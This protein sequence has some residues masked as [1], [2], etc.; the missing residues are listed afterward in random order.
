MGAPGSSTV[1]QTLNYTP[2]DYLETFPFL[3]INSKILTQLGERYHQDR[4]GI[5]RSDE[6]GLT[7]FYNRIHDP[8]E[9]DPR[10]V[11]FRELQRTLDSE[12]A[13]AYS[14]DDLSLGHSFHQ[15]TYLPKNDNIR[16]SIAENARTEILR[17]LA[18]LNKE[19]HEANKTQGKNTKRASDATKAK[20]GSPGDLFAAQGGNS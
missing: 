8:D 17:R 7:Q 10:I 16:F 4:T 14:W 9:Q 15:V 2:S 19:R 20:H 18:Q 11:E 5:M 12:V 6:I 13:K 3:H 1:G